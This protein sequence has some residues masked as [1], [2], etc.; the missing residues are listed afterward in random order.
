MLSMSWFDKLQRL[1]YPIKQNPQMDAPGTIK[2]KKGG[3]AHCI[4]TQIVLMQ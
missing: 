3:G 2:I 4:E 1:G